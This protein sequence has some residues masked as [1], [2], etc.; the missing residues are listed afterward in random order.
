V[1]AQARAVLASLDLIS[2]DDHLLEVAATLDPSILRTLDA[3]HLAT[4]LSLGDSLDKVITYDKRM[5]EAAQYL[6]LAVV[7]PQAGQH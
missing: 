7:S 3:I 4:A 6:G 5:A 2:L 1:K